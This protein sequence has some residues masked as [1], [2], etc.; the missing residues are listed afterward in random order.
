[1]QSRVSCFT[2]MSTC[3]LLVDDEPRNLLALEALLGPLGHRLV[4]AT[5]GTTALEAFER[6]LPDLVICDL[7]MPG[8][9][10][11]E[12][13]QRVRAHASRAHTP[14]IVVTAYAEREDRIRAMRAGADEFLEK[15]VDEAIL[16]AR[17]ATLLRL[18]RSRDELLAQHAALQQVRREQREL[19]E[20]VVHDVKT[21]LGTL[22]A[23][24]MQI[25]DNLDR[26]AN[27]LEPL[28]ARVDAAAKRLAGSLEDL[29]WISRLEHHDF[30]VFCTPVAIA[31]AMRRVVERFGP[32]A[33]VQD[34]ELSLVSQGP[35]TLSTDERLIGRVLENLLE[36]AIRYAPSGGRVQI[37]LRA[38]EDVEL[39]VCNDGPPVP[40]IE[41]RRIFD[42]FVRGR[43]EAPS[44]GHAGLGLYFCRRAV[45]ALHGE[46]EVA[47]VAGWRTAF[48]VRLPMSVTQRAC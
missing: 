21:P 31:D 32:S 39:L 28:L 2:G 15:P 20:F 40:A 27:V 41:R 17:V 13:L 43:N 12:V 5:S 9:D 34:V 4:R 11:V 36:N 38:G 16:R 48:S 35:I 22:R 3:L 18:K 23:G 8:V 47:D 24:L 33:A 19:T 44:P 29:L 25:R 45:E 26:G 1:M 14:V 30:P 37:E 46:I 10:G 6:E 42:K 7:V